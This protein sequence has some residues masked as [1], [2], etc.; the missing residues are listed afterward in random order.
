MAAPFL[1]QAVVFFFIA[2]PYIVQG[3]QMAQK[4]YEALP[5]KILWG[6]I[7]FLMCFCGGVFPA[8]IAA[9]EAWSLC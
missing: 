1:A 6:I 9:V 3:F 2:L 5:D 8:T 7:G 4:A